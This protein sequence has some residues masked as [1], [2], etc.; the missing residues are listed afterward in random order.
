MKQE[1][2][3]YKG[4]WI[5]ELIKTALQLPKSQRL[6]KTLRIKKILE[7]NT[8]LKHRKGLGQD[9]DTKIAIEMKLKEYLNLVQLSHSAT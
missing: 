9:S 7:T 5:T 1:I 8:S 2:T 4:F 6:K 3:K